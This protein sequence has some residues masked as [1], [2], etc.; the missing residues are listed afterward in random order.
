[1]LG[2]L[3]VPG[4]S[5]YLHPLGDGLL[6]GVGQDAT[7]E[8]QTTGAQVSLFDIA[9]LRNPVRRGQI[10]F[11]RAYSE[12][13]ADHHAFLWWAPSALAVVPVTGDAEGGVLGAVAFRADRAGG[14]REVRRLEHGSGDD[15]AAI[16]RSLVVGGSLVTVSGSGVMSTPLDSLAGGALTRFP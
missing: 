4:Y 7:S 16:L 9:D 6:L 12:V 14:L 3:K 10:G 15:R 11:P 2:E 8:G 13:E 1:V 5:A